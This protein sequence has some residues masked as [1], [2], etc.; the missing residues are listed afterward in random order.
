[1]MVRLGQKAKAAR[2]TMG[3]ADTVRPTAR[4]CVA[5]RSPISAHVQSPAGFAGHVNLQEMRTP[6]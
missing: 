1:M 3:L 4:R 5:V 2:I 6:R